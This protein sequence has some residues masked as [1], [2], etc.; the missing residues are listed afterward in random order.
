MH[1]KPENASEKPLTKEMWLSWDREYGPRS[2]ESNPTGHKNPNAKGLAS[3]NYRAKEE[4]S[5]M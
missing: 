5:I 2:P 3:W 4:E 1:A